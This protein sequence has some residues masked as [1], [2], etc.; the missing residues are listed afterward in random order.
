M[1]NFRL[2]PTSPPNNLRITT[3]TPTSISLSWEA[4]DVS[5][6]NGVLLN[7]TIAYSVQ[8]EPVIERTTPDTEI[9][10]RDLEEFTEYDITVSASTAEGVGPV[11]EITQRT[12]EDG[13]SMVVTHKIVN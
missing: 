5:E 6:Q 13:E 11:A 10:L 3:V 12:L 1:H 4:P 8:S 9:T 2:A 7:Y